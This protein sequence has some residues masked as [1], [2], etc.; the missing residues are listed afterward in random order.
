MPATMH[1]L[2]PS[3]YDSFAMAIL[4]QNHLEINTAEFILVNRKVAIKG[5]FLMMSLTIWPP[6]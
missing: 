6:V 1:T 4:S 5:V 3:N 2:G